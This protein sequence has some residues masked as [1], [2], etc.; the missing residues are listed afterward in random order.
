MSCGIYKIEN[1]INHHIYI[2]KAKNIENRWS[3]HLSEA[4]Y[5]RKGCAALNHA[6]N[7]YGKD[8]FILSIIENI[9]EE[10]YPLIASDRER[11]WINHY[12][13]F[14]N[15]NHYNLTEG[16]Q[17]TSGWHPSEEWKAKQSQ[18]KKEYYQTK[19]GQE[20][21]K[22]HSIF[23]KQYWKTHA[24]PQIKHDKKWKVNHSK[25]MSGSNNPNYGKHSNG[26]KCLCIELNQIF[27]STREASQKMGIAHTGIAAACR[28]IQKTSGGYHWKYL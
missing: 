24:A 25:R 7:K 11:F 13:S 17:G 20:R 28:G 1:K 2:G 16:G 12:N 23:L 26:K 5:N 4:K 6:I 22:E 19:E 10:Q 14:K 21:K 27:Q 3:A 9:P 18:L 15:P 8:N